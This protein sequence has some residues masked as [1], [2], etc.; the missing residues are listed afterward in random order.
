[1]PARADDTKLP[2]NTTGLSARADGDGVRVYFR[3]VDSG[4]VQS[5]LFTG[6]VPSEVT[7]LGDTSGYG[8]VGAAGPLLAGRTASGALATL[9]P[10]ADD[11]QWKSERRHPVHRRPLGRRRTA[12]PPRRPR[13]AWTAS[14][15]GRR[16]PAPTA[17]PPPG[18][19]RRELTAAASQAGT[20]AQV[21][22]RSAAGAATARPAPAALG[23]SL[24]AC[25]AP[26]GAGPAP[27]PAA[28]TAG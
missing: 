5:V 9:E 18:S 28:S 12:R 7:D 1:M 26:P 10:G 19:P 25:A 21:F 24:P 2:P 22:S 16:P 11:P 20:S 27:V 4:N 17:R 6:V 14:C 3:K 15:T 13:S 8:M 23:T